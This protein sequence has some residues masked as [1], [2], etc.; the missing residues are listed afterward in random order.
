MTQ[1]PQVGLAET[2]GAAYGDALLAAIAV[3]AA[4]LDTV[5]A[6]EGERLAPGPA[7]AE[8][9]DEL[10][11]LYR[12]LYPA[13]ASQAHALARLQRRANVLLADRAG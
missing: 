9:Y 13:T 3:G 7:T 2:T 11:G 5:W 6:A 1:L 12:E 4:G 8:L 10:Y